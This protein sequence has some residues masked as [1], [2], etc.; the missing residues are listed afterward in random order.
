VIGPQIGDRMALFFGLVIVRYASSR[1]CILIAL[2][3][4]YYFPCLAPGFSAYG[5]LC[6]VI[7]VAPS[8]LRASGAVVTTV[9]SV[10][11]TLGR[12][13]VFPGSL[14]VVRLRSSFGGCGITTFVYWCLVPQGVSVVTRAAS[15]AV[16]FG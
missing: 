13:F 3:E 16:W 10:T 15:P 5:A 4:L 2:S 8:A 11:V 7:P 12:I 14:S 9:A 1:R 6:V